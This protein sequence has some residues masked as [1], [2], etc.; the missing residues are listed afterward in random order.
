MILL[1]SLVEVKTGEEEETALFSDRGFL[2]RYVSETKEWKE[3]GRGDMKIL[4]HKVTNRI[5]LLVRREQVLFVFC[6]IN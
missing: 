2:Y 3:K 1:P 6:G 5:R 4:Q